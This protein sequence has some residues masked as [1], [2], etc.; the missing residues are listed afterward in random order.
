MGTPDTTTNGNWIFVSLFR[1]KYKNP[2]EVVGW[3][4]Y[5]VA[6]SAFATTVMAVI[7][8]KYYAGVVAGGAEGTVLSILGWHIRVPGASAFT[9]SV[10]IAMIV[11]AL[12]APL[13][14]AIADFS[15]V[16]KRFLFGYCLAGSIF[17]AMLATVGPGDVVWG[18]CLFM[19][20]LVGFSGGNVFYNA[21]LP[22]SQLKRIWAK[23]RV[24]AG[25]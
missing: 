17:T 2:Q 10:A 1:F 23:Y 15:G 13:L 6:N 25:R 11:V 20:A 7:F 8:N 14:G 12:T 5:D 4:F 21:L 18:G 22:E 19:L 16:K 9:F 3:S 24:L